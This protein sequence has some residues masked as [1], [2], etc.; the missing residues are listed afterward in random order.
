MIEED[1]EIQVGDDTIDAVLVRDEEGRRLP[2]VLHLTDIGGIRASN[3]KLSRRIAEEGYTVLMPNVFHRNGKPPMWEWQRGSDERS[4][5]RFAELTAP[6]PPAVQERD[7]AAYVDFLAAHPA[8]AGDA[9]A[10]AGYCFTGA[11]ALRTAAAR[12]RHIAA[13]A[14]YHGG[15]LWKDDPSS[16]H[17]VLPRVAA[18]LYFGHAEDDYSMPA[19]AIEQLDRALAAWGGRYESEVYAGAHHGWTQEDTAA[20]HPAQAEHAFEKL[21]DLLAATLLA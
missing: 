4:K 9:M 19:A 8:V 15:G 12:P 16:P 1:I 13:A 21:I 18:R 3:R 6:L 7:G 20:Y 5:R 2:G 11:I 14:S 10:V 17:L